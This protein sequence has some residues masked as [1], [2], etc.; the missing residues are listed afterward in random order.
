MV[1]KERK[2]RNMKDCVVIGVNLKPPSEVDCSGHT[3]LFSE[4]CQTCGAPIDDPFPLVCTRKSGDV[5]EC[6][7]LLRVESDGN[8]RVVVIGSLHSSARDTKL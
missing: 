2:R 8:K 3:W 5:E 6:K 7:C 4:F 1:N